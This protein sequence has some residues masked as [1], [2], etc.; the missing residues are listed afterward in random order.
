MYFKSSQ[1]RI[2]I[3]RTPTLIWLHPI[4]VIPTLLIT[5]QLNLLCLVVFHL[6]CFV[7]SLYWW[8]PLWQLVNGSDCELYLFFVLF[9]S[10]LSQNVTW[11]AVITQY[12]W[13]ICVNPVSMHSVESVAYNILKNVQCFFF[14]IFYSLESVRGPGHQQVASPGLLPARGPLLL[15][16]A[17]P[18]SSYRVKRN[19]VTLSSNSHSPT[20]NIFTVLSQKI[21]GS[22][23]FLSKIYLRKSTSIFNV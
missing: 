14:L 10:V 20:V 12:D 8:C 21:Y 18:Y 6:L 4:L 17:E 23:R 7:E 11:V 13:N 1:G 15:A 3:S 5:P 2:W 16:P 9:C 22:Y 19:S